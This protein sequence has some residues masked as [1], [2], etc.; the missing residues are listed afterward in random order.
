MALLPIFLIWLGSA[1]VAA[2]AEPSAS[3][4]PSVF[5]ET[6][7]VEA[8]PITTTAGS[9]TVLDRETIAAS[10]GES[11]ADV[12]D[13]LAGVNVL[14]S[15]SRAGVSNAF[16][17]AGDPNFT[18]VLLDGVPLNDPTER[19]GGA[20]NLEEWPAES[21]GRVEVVRG[22]RSSF[23]GP[24]SLAGVVQLFTPRGGPGPTRA[25]LGADVGDA[26]LR[27]AAGRV[28]GPAGGGGYSAGLA[29]EQETARIAD[30]RFRA[31][32]GWG[33]WD[34]P[35]GDSLLAFTLRAGTG[36]SD[37]YP[38]ASGGPTL[39]DGVLRLDERLDL[40]LGVRW[41]AGD[42]GRRHRTSLA[43]ER[44]ALDRD[45]P[46]VFPLV[47]AS[48]E[49]TSYLRLRAGHDRPL[50]RTSRTW[51]DAGLTGEI[52]RA[53][54]ESVLRLPPEAGGD[55]PGDYDET[56]AIG[57]A[58]AGVRH[59][60]GRWLAEA[61]LRVDASSP[62]SLHANPSAGLVWNAGNTRVRA[63]AGR[64]SK[65]PSFF[66][67]SSPPA[68]GGNPDLKPETSWGGEIGV[69]QTVG[70]RLEASAAL[71]RQEY[72]DLVDFDFDLFTHVNR[73]S[74]RANGAELA[75]RWRAA[76]TLSLDGH[77]TWL[78][79]SVPGGAPLLHRA[80]WQGGGR[81]T[82]TPVTAVRL[83]LES[84]GISSYLDQQIPVIDRDTVPGY[85]V[86]NA[87]GSWRV[88][89]GWTLRARVDNLGNRDYETYI[90]FPGAG[91][92]FRGGVTWTTRGE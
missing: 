78:D 74:V 14:S 22:P 11:V 5:F 31:A 91:R 10:G 28:S 80:R 40:A 16:V 36:E 25:F 26:D 38:D 32:S 81:V 12:L 23:Y 89:E 75:L 2:A 30:D 42:A 48:I 24:A 45:S 52:E 83:A 68:L 41:E 46:A 92:S 85:G 39:G 71:F 43:F 18:L 61:A 70:S 87:T 79:A 90:G 21:L 15:G 56:R 3:P 37:D 82:W 88:R 6:T 17:R 7:T 8:R 69:E 84:R 54:N 62:G 77:A 67:L 1:V 60:R 55:I 59:Q 35:I 73:A 47:P 9:V 50:V 44:R 65:E 58:Y 72:R 66:A 49:E 53:R 4:T 19:Q 20:V 34:R 33:T 64:A 63:A 57:G 86:W 51:M 29:W 13:G 76:P 27:R